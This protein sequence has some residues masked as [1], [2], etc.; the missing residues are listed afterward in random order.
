MLKIK[1]C[2]LIMFYILFVLCQQS[3]HAAD[4]KFWIICRNFNTPIKI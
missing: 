1:N 4:N 3:W 2:K